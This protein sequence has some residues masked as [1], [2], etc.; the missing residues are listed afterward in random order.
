MSSLKSCFWGW[1]ALFWTHFWA[2]WGVTPIAFEW[3]G[4]DPPIPTCPEVESCAG[5]GG[6]G[7][8]EGVRVARAA[9]PG[10][11]E[12]RGGAAEAEEGPAPRP[13][14]PPN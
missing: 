6:A 10:A 9:L 3:G 7:A 4:S 2:L 12:G 14:G 1:C 11:D 5:G 13:G 8:G